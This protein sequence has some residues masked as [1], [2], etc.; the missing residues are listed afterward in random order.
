[1]RRSPLRSPPHMRGKAVRADDAA[2]PAGITPAYAGKRRRRWASGSQDRDHPRVC[3]EKSANPKVRDTMEGASPRMRGKV[4]FFTG[5]S[6]YAIFFLEPSGNLLLEPSGSSWVPPDGSIFVFA[7]GS[8]PRVRGKVKVQSTLRL[9]RR[10]HPRVCGEKMV[11][12][13]PHRRS[14]GSPPRMRGKATSG[15]LSTLVCRITPAYAGKSPTAKQRGTP[16]RDH[17]PRV[18]GKVHISTGQVGGVGITPAY[19]GKRSTATKYFQQIRDHPRVCGEKLPLT[20]PGWWPWGSPPRM[21]GKEH[22][23][24]R[25][26]HSPRITPAYA[27]KSR[28]QGSHTAPPGDHPRVCGEKPVTTRFASSFWGSPPRMRG[29]DVDALGLVC[30]FGITPAYAGKRWCQ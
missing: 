18:R 13:I 15:C 30:R 25:Q 26:Q 17:P 29:K 28:S 8:P 5:A 1:M 16:R 22:V 24:L 19:A 3:G 23:R 11:S 10:D 4:F 12:M 21:R 6:F 7:I 20:G 14:R 27:G 2:V 9:E